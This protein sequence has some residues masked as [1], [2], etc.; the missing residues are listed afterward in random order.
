MTSSLTF[1]GYIISAKGIK[2]DPIKIEIREVRGFHGLA[3]FYRRFVKN[4]STVIAPIIDYLKKGTFKWTPEADTT[5]QLIKSKM[6]QTPI[7]SLPNFEKVYEVNCDA[8]HVG[9]GAVLSQ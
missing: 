7:L 2:V 5:F 9:I 8:S 6:S 4:F 3:S 1:L